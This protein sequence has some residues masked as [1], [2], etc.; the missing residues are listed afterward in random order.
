[1]K[2]LS[3]GAAVIVFALAAI[4]VRA[5]G[6]CWTGKLAGPGGE[7]ALEPVG[8]L[9]AG[10]GPAPVF[11]F[12]RQVRDVIP[13]QLPNPLRFQAVFASSPFGSTSVVAMAGAPL[14]GAAGRQSFA[15]AD[16]TGGFGG[17]GVFSGLVGDGGYWRPTGDGLYRLKRS[18]GSGT[19]GFWDASST[20]LDD[21]PEPFTLL[22]FGTGLLM[23]AFF[24][25]WRFGAAGRK[26]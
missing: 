16:G 22:L 23:I 24:A 8:S 12:A 17:V 21:T 3:I 13:L 10:S 26:S 4:P 14:T 1:M 11:E 15:G 5:N 18:W 19:M 2:G 9:A 6:L 20:Q 7:C 25:K